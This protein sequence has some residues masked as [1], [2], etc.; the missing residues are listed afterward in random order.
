MVQ[1]HQSFVFGKSWC[2]VIKACLENHGARSS[3]LAWKIMVQGHQS[4]VF[5]KSWCKVIKAL[6]LYEIL[7]V[8]LLL[9]TGRA[10]IKNAQGYD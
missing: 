9:L 10:E 8:N 3:K 2:K 1:G 5:A 7:Q 6:C 4:F